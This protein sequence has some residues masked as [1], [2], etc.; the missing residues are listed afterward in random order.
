VRRDGD[1][2]V[3]ASIDMTGN[4]LNN[5]GFPT[6]ERNVATKAYVNS[7]SAA[8]KVSKSS[9]TMTGDLLVN[10]ASDAV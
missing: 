5:V 6:S 3:T 1:N 7:N 10:A 9:D 4:T 2:T 8:D